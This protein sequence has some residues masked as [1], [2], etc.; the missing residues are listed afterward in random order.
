MTLFHFYVELFFSGQCLIFRLHRAER[1]ER[2]HF[3]HAPGVHNL[4]SVFVLECFCHGSRASRSADHDTLQMRKLAASLFKIL[5]QHQPYCWHR[6]RERN[7][8]S[9][10]Q[11]VDRRS[12]ELCTRHH[13]CGA[14]HR[15]GEGEGPA[16]RMEKR[17]DRQ[18]DVARR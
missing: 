2:A 11:F 6:C 17:H 7:L 16:I 3:G 14:D 1:A 13:H 18:D 4:N 10:E 12:V 8:V 5:E 9:I 15:R